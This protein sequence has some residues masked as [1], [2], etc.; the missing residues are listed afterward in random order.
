MIAKVFTPSAFWGGLSQG[1]VC[2]GWPSSCL[3][4]GHVV[5][6]VGGIV[7]QSLCSDCEVWAEGLKLVRQAAWRSGYT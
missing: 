6:I 4:A 5:M 7:L 2:I 3:A 1:G